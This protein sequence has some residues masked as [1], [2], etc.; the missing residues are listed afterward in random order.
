M[1]ATP[2]TTEP[3]DDEVEEGPSDDEVDDSP[4]A[5]ERL[6]GRNVSRMCVTTRKWKKMMMAKDYDGTS[7]LS[8]F[9]TQFE[10]CAEY[11]EWDGRDKVAYLK[12]SLTGN[13]VHVLEDGAGANMS[14]T[15]LVG[16]LKNRYGTEGQ[17]SSFKML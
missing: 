1:V 15:E 10:S 4:I 2:P 17:A 16:R 11:N 6:R 5:T 3:C 12:N 8:V 13:A 9:L 14:Y 7:L